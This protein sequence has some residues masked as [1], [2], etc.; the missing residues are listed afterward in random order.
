MNHIS[1]GLR[2]VVFYLSAAGY[3]NAADT[4]TQFEIGGVQISLGAGWTIQNASN[5]QNEKQYQNIERR[6]SVRAK[7]L[8]LPMSLPLPLYAAINIATLSDPAKLNRETL[9]E[10]VGVSRS[11]LDDALASRYAAGKA[12]KDVRAQL[13]HVAKHPQNNGSGFEIHSTL[14]RL[15]TN[16]MIYSRQFLLPRPNRSDIVQITFISANKDIL[17]SKEFLDAIRPTPRAK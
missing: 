2:F 5:A 7:T 11:D 12:P 17:T 9:A 13:L 10:Q 6:M 8:L 16:E 15:D 4:G 3:I 1:L 14:T